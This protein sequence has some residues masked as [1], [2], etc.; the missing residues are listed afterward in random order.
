MSKRALVE[1][2][3]WLLASVVAGVAFYFLWNNAVAEGLWGILLKGSAVG[4]LAIYAMRRTRGADGAILVI[5]LA[6]S[7]AGD[8]VLE[9][10]FMAGG[11]LFAISHLVAII[12]YAR[13]LR[14]EPAPSQYLGALAF[15]I[16]GPLVSWLLSER[17]DLA[18]YG[19]VL[20]AMAAGAWMSRFRRTRVALGAALFVVSDWLIFS[21]FGTF[22][23]GVLPDILVW[24]LYYAGQVMIATG[25]VQTLRADHES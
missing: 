16:A 2:R 23:L 5:A 13:N 11:V 10:D 8:M 21:R 14:D 15:V 24:P 18:V 22:N 3:P 4:L 1:H 12:L 6:L 17:V 25:V 20:G 9:L 19:A 7:A